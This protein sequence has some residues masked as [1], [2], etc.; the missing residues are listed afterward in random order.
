M[1]DRQF[2]QMLTQIMATNMNT[3]WDANDPASEFEHIYTML[4]DRLNEE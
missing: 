1:N 2:L 3:D 4:I